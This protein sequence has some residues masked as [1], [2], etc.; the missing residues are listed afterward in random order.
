MKDKAAVSQN[1]RAELRWE[2]QPMKRKRP[3]KRRGT[4]L[5]FSDRHGLGLALAQHLG[6]VGEIAVLIFPGHCYQALKDEQWYWLN[7]E[8]GADF[9]RLILEPRLNH[10]P[11]CRRVIHLWALDHLAQQNAKSAGAAATSAYGEETL[12]HLFNALALGGRCKEQRLWRVVRGEY[13]LEPEA[14]AE[15][16]TTVLSSQ[17]AQRDICQ[18]STIGWGSIIDLD[19]SVPAGEAEQL[20]EEIWHGGGNKQV[21]FRAGRRYVA[22]PR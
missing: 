10:F 20:F 2:M 9:E 21:A 18:E 4:W 14:A 12:T 1:L 8:N 22:H 13:R 3:N 6:E 11:P 16:F 15:T 5:I 19:P 7:P 17:W